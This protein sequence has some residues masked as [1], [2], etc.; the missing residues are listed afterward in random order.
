[1][2]VD[3]LTRTLFL[4]PPVPRIGKYQFWRE[5]EANL[6]IHCWCVPRESPGSIIKQMGIEREKIF[7]L[8]QCLNLVEAM[9]YFWNFFIA[10]AITFPASRKLGS[11]LS[12]YWKENYRNF[13]SC[14][15][16]SFFKAH[17]VTCKQILTND[18]L[19][20]RNTIQMCFDASNILLMRD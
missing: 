5:N 16:S 1:M 8:K 17:H 6:L 18:V 7:F 4:L 9:T 15:F 19:Q 10:T 12:M 14:C 20:M 11:H 2:P 3:G 13:I